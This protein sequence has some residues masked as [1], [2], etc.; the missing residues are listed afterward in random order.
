M[1]PMAL[2]DL[3]ECIEVLQAYKISFEALI[4]INKH[5]MGEL[6]K[7]PVNFLK[8]IQKSQAMKELKPGSNCLKAMHAYLKK[9]PFPKLLIG[10]TAKPTAQFP[11]PQNDGLLHIDNQLARSLPALPQSNRKVFSPIICNL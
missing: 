2:E 6:A 5:R 1:S 4:E 9:T 7:N 3:T 8:K 11:N 10:T